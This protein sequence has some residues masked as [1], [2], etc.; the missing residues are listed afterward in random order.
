MGFGKRPCRSQDFS[1]AAPVSTQ[2]TYSVP[3]LNF[4]LD[5]ASPFALF[6][7]TLVSY[8]LLDSH[9]ST[10]RTR[11]QSGCGIRTFSPHSDSL[12]VAPVPWPVRA[13]HSLEP[14]CCISSDIYC[15]TWILHLT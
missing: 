10:L 9:K 3:Q 4:T 8:C 1:S 5:T 12:A 2:L 7:P 11:F 6:R 14:T 15:I 13:V